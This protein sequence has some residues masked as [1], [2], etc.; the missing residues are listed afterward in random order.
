MPL[1][2]SV[3]DFNF[4]GGSMGS[5]LGEKIARLTRRSAERH[6]PLVIVSASGGARMQE[7]VLSLMQMA[8]TSV[9]IAR[10]RAARVPFVSIMI[11][12]NT[13]GMSAMYAV[14]GDVVMAGTGTVVGFD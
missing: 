8:K 7:G 9:E 10:L 3:M 13:G 4:M 5:V 11:N 2:D 14:A 1:D 6:V 12:L